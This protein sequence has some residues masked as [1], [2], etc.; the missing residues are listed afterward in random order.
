MFSKFKMQPLFSFGSIVC[1]SLRDI[2]CPFRFHL[3]ERDRRGGRVG[4][5]TSHIEVIREAYDRGQKSVMIFE[6]DVVA[7]P[8]YN[9]KIIREICRYLEW[10]LVQFGYGP[11]CPFSILRFIASGRA[12]FKMEWIADTRICRLSPGNGK[13]FGSCSTYLDKASRPSSPSR[14]I[15]ICRSKTLL[16][17]HTNAI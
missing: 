10:E 14:C 2:D 15:F 17:S 5:F 11:E 7:T 3:V 9:S 4:C 12:S 8:A 1:I 6:D 16:C 13:D